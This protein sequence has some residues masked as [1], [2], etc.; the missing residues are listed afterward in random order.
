[1]IGSQAQARQHAIFLA[2]GRHGQTG[3]GHFL[4]AEQASATAHHAGAALGAQQP[5]L[6]PLAHVGRF[7]GAVAF[8]CHRNT[9]VKMMASA[10]RFSSI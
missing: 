8:G 10:I 4:A 3:V 1:L 2:R 6:A 7:H 5:W 9:R